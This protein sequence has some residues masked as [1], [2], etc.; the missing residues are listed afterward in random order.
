VTLQALTLQEHT[1][2]KQIITKKTYY[3]PK[4]NY[5][6]KRYYDNNRYDD[7]YDRY[8]DYDDKRYLKQKTKKYYDDRYDNYKKPKKKYS[9]QKNYG[10]KND[11]LRFSSKGNHRQ[12]PGIFGNDLNEYKVNVKNKEHKGGYFTVKFQLTDHY[13]KTRT[14]VSTKYLK[15]YE[16]RKFV[17]K[18]VFDDGKKYKYWTYKT[19]SHS[20]I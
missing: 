9:S 17:Y 14:E 2:Y 13:G 6:K 16:N 12:S 11:Y 4:K 18:N 19:V 1:L 15:P 10:N 20:K 3:K 8:D 7:Y 5:K